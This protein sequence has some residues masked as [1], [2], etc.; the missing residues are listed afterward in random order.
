MQRYLPA[1]G[2]K[3]RDWRA[4]D[5]ERKKAKKA[6]RF[7]WSPLDRKR[8]LGVSGPLVAAELLQLAN[9]FTTGEYFFRA[10]S[11]TRSSFLNGKAVY[12]LSE[13][14]AEESRFEVNN[15]G[16]RRQSGVN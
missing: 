10:L 9:F 5:R 7:W 8:G 6:G 12:P 4:T 16:F 3:K 13:K 14:E 11:S 15:K 1:T 2:P